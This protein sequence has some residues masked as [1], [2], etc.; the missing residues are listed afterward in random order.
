[1]AS[2]EVSLK[3]SVNVTVQPAN[4]VS[5]DSLTINRVVD[6]ADQQEVRAWVREIPRPI[7]VWKG[8]SYP[9]NGGWNYDQVK[10]KIKADAEGG[11][12]VLG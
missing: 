8:A 4:A 3:A 11:T 2:H 5:V 1:M 6:L 10:A 7:V 12:L 9:A